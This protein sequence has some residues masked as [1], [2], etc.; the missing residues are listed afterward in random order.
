MHHKLSHATLSGI[1]DLG[2]VPP[3]NLYAK[4]QELIADGQGVDIVQLRAKDQ[5]PRDI[6]QWAQELKPLCNQHGV[7]FIIND[8]PEIAVKVGADGVHIGQDDGSLEHARAIVGDDM[9]IGRSTHSLTQAQQAL[10]DGFDYI[11]FGPLYLTPTK[12]GRPAI[13]LEDLQ[14]VQ[15][16]VGRHIP[17][18]A[19]GGIKPENL[20]QV[21]EKGGKR[22]VIVSALLTPV[23]SRPLVTEVKVSLS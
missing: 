8:Y 19:I 4:A 13:G 10:A 1:I 9:L 18:F 2:Y 12:K 23:D 6:Y 16:T 17:V 5:D 22:V 11:G 21:Q 7:P 15:S 3:E 14:E 20:S